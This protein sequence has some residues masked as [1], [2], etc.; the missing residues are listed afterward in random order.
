MRSKQTY[1]KTFQENGGNAI[2]S[3]LRNNNRNNVPT[4]PA[5]TIFFRFIWWNGGGNI[6][7]RLRTNPQLRKLLSTKPDVFIYG[8]AET[9]S[10]HNLNMNDYDCFLHKSKLEIDGH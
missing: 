7:M 8:E 5:N 3:H 2:H 4:G 1:V 9:P 10:S 6:R